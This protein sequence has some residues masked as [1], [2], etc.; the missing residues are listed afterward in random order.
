MMN[1][2]NRT[3]V[4][5]ITFDFLVGAEGGV[6]DYDF[7]RRGAGLRWDVVSRGHVHTPADWSSGRISPYSRPNLEPKN[8]KEHGRHVHREPSTEHRREDERVPE[9][10]GK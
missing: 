9:Q 8:D 10:T 6:A 5:E 1:K 2:I 7:V 3:T 4:S